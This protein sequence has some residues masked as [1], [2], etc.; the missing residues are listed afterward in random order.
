MRIAAEAAEERGDLLVHHRVVGDVGD[1]L[2]LLVAGRQFAVQQ[3]ISDFEEVAFVGQLL[4]RVT[5]IHQDP[6]VAV[7]IGNAGSTG[8]GRHKA[9][10][11]GE[12]S[13][14]RVKAADVDYL[15]AD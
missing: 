5:P 13:G 9:R 7:D 1:E 11:V 3:Q 8:G 12:I 4:D 14:F 10:V 15:G 6:L 2:R